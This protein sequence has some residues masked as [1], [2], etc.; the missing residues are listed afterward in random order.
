[1]MLETKNNMLHSRELRVLRC[2]VLFRETER[3]WE[4]WLITKTAFPSPRCDMSCVPLVGAAR[5][6]YELKHVLVKF[7]LE[8]GHR[9]VHRKLGEGATR[10]FN[11]G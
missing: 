2:V 9:E 8:T 7:R 6:R 5:S 4:N 11:I 10:F 1:M 3:L